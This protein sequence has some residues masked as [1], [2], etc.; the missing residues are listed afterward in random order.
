MVMMRLVC[1]SHVNDARLVALQLGLVVLAVGD[2]DDRVAPMHQAGG[3]AV[4]LDLSRAPHA[5]D[6]VGL[7][8]RAVVDVDHMHLLVLEDVG[9][10]QQ[11]RVDRDRPDIVQV[12]IGDRRPVDL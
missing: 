11:V 4:D 3:G 5:G 2:H 9:G 12:A 7:K 8:A 1:A 10:L 6:R